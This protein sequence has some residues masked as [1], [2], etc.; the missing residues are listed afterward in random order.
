MD[1]KKNILFILHLPPPV[2]GSSLVGKSI[3]E[4]KSINQSFECRFINLLVSR[5]VN[6]TGKTSFLKIFRFVCVWFRLLVEL[7]KKKPDI[8]YLAL[9]ATGAAFYK[10]ILLVGLLRIFGIK[11]V[12]HMH[13]KGISSNQSG[14]MNKFLYRFVFEDADVILLSRH[15]YHDVESFVSESRMHICPNGIEDDFFDI[16][17][18]FSSSEEVAK[19]L[20]L[21]NLI[22][23]KGVFVLLEACSILQQKGIDF[24]CDFIGAEGDLNALKFNEKVSQLQLSPKVNY[25]GKRFGKEKQEALLNADIFAFPTFYSKECFPLVILEAMSAGLPVVSTY[26]GGIHD[27]VEDGITGFLVPQ[28]DANALAEKLEFFIVNKNIRKQMGETGRQKFENDF[29]LYKFEDRMIEIL[30]EI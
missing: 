14:R 11:R 24:T 16:K 30:S 3:K 7:I 28:N 5:N 21:S 4:S 17:P 19:I 6:E 15:L 23:S 9:T 25:L 20:F 29:E 1:K 8:C 13:N 10:D 2:H 27:I 22:I 26:E 12:Y 18:E